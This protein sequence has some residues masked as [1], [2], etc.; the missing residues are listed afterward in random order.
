MFSF[1]P[2]IVMYSDPYSLNPDLGILLDTDPDQAFA[3][4]KDPIRIQTKIY[5]DKID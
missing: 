2:Q 5:Y 4:F 3:D 1:I